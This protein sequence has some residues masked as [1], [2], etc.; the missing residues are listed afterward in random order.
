VVTKRNNRAIH[1]GYQIFISEK[2][3]SIDDVGRKEREGKVKNVSQNIYWKVG[4]KR[5]S[6]NDRLPRLILE[7]EL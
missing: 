5:N 3:Y 4:G 2:E 7:I 6:Q 1:R